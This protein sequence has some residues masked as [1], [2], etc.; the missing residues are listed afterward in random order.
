MCR[1]IFWSTLKP[2]S[3]KTSYLKPP[4]PLCMHEPQARLINALCCCL[5][6]GRRLNPSLLLYFGIRWCLHERFRSESC[7]NP[8]RGLP[9]VSISKLTQRNKTQQQA[10]PRYGKCDVSNA[11]EAGES[12]VYFRDSGCVYVIQR[13]L[14]T[15][16][17]CRKNGPKLHPLR[18]NAIRCMLLYGLG[19]CADGIVLMFME[20]Q[21]TPHTN[22][23]PA[24]L[25]FTVHNPAHIMHPWHP[26]SPIRLL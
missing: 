7:H 24:H 5:T 9:D 2:N 17:Q 3:S 14:R 21:T 15:M 4:F 11:R 22:Q 19:C 23:N 8:A 25:L 13:V 26:L 1:R 20:P 12:G 6:Y 18:T 10:K 16:S